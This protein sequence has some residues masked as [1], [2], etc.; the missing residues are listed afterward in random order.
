MSQT[1]GILGVAA[2]VASDLVIIGLPRALGPIIPDC[3]ISEHHVDRATVTHHPVEQ[4][5]MISDHM[6]QE[7][8]ELTL[9][10]A[11]SDAGSYPG[12]SIDT[13]NALQA[14]QRSRVPITIITGKR[15]YINMVIQELETET[16]QHSETSLFVTVNCIEVILVATSGTTL[17]SASGTPASGQA[18]SLTPSAPRGSINTTPASTANIPDFLAA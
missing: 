3:A 4:G 18:P 10:Y 14:L 8:N 1:L 5:A 17:P 15:I 16:D 2:L 11:W 7:P 12:W 6:Y 9:R 13:Y